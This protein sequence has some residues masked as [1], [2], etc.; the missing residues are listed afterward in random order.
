MPAFRFLCAALCT[1]LL[2]AG[3]QQPT[4][5]RLPPFDL[6]IENIT[7]VDAF[8]GT[9]TPSTVLLRGNVIAAV[10]AADTPLPPTVPR[11]DG[12]D[13]F[14]IPGLWDMHVH[15][16]YEPALNDHFAALL[17]DYGITSV[18]D[19]GGVLPVLLPAVERW[20]NADVPTPHLYWSGPLLDGRLVVYDGNDRPL[21]GVQ[22][23]S[24]DGAAARVKELKARG[25]SFIKIYEMVEDP[26]FDA[27][28]AAARAENLPIAAH[29]PLAVDALKAGP[30]LQSLEHL[31]NLDLACSE[32]AEALLAQRRNTIAGTPNGAGFKLR[33]ALH[34][35]QRRK[36]QEG[37]TVTSR[38]CE[39]V[40][41]AFA[42]TVHVPTLRLNTISRFSP[43]HRS[44]W[45]TALEDLPTVLA[46]GW[47][48]QATY[49]AG[50]A[51]PVSLNNADWSLALTQAL[52]SRGTTIGAGTDSPIAQSIPGYALH[53]E[54]ERLVDAGLSPREALAAA[55]VAPS[56]FFGWAETRAGRVAAEHPADLIVLSANPLEDITNTR[57]IET[58]ILNGRVVRGAVNDE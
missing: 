58:V 54:L 19:T 30:E 36:A 56:R 9:G 8:D 2:F 14:L 29:I 23:A 25:A 42:N 1:L 20:V 31:R 45:Q 15:I 17:L 18:R 33:S 16:T 43:L 3:C 28:V 38:R 24:A 7:P 13:R 57:R 53:T 47:L 10:V 37:L 55:T 49:F 39:A 26:V 40:M 32:D 52:A 21:I 48:G 22:N 34:R 46:E 6:A 27:L 12:R 41:T 4:V 44:D 11:I 50:R 35:E 51:T 5:A